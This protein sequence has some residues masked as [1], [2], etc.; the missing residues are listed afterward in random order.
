MWSH[1]E[2]KEYLKKN[3]KK[4]RYEHSLGVC[5]T[6][7]KLAKIYG[8]NE[9]KSYIA[10]LIHD[11]AKNMADEEIIKTIEDAG[12]KINILSLKMPQL[13]HGLAGSIIASNAMQVKDRDILDSITYHTTGRENMSLLE[14]IIYLADFI[15]PS[16]DFK[17]V[18]ELRE[19]SYKN[20][21]KA[22]LCAFNNSIKFVIEK[23]EILHLDTVKARNYMIINKVQE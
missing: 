19:L 13:L 23:H 11:C 15:E 10:G 20:L 12:I 21:D 18:E 7:V 3:L 16:R 4:S 6:A 1:S 22:L 17:G 8:E 5:E 14:K 2:M 9:E